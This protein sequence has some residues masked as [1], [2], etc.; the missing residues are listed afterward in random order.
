MMVSGWPGIQLDRR[1]L[2]RRWWRLC[3][4]EGTLNPRWVSKQVTSVHVRK[5]STQTVIFDIG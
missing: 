5:Y 4:S 2:N 3:K 1:L